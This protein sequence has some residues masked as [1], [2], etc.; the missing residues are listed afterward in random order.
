M[1]ISKVSG[2]LW[3]NVAKYGGVSKANIANLGGQSAPS[4]GGGPAW[5][6]T[7]YQFEDQ[8]RSTSTSLASYWSPNNTHSDWVNGWDAINS[9]HTYSLVGTTYKAWGKSS[10]PA[11]GWNCDDD[12][13]GSGSTGP[14]GGVV[15]PGGTHSTSTS[16]DMYLYTEVSSQGRY[17]TFVVRTPGFNFSTL[18]GDTSRNLDLKF[19][20]HAYGSQMGDLFT[21]IDEASTSSHTDATAL[22]SY[23]S[24][25]GFTSNSSVWQQKTISLNNYRTVN[26]NHYIYF[27]AEGFGGFRGDMA[28][29]G[30]QI[31]ES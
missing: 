14:N 24:F 29:D 3:A 25:S 15:I 5:S 6:S 22:T 23:T 19:W 21:Y 31:V 30:I 28:I 2:V 26:S 11:T 16:T 1:A 20:V 18:M 8:S 7:L 9:S 4:S 10:R 17:Y 12:G 27:A 13:T